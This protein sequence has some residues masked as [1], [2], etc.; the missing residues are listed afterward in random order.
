MAATFKLHGGATEPK[1][2]KR[3]MTNYSFQSPLWLRFTSSPSELSGFRLNP[4]SMRPVN[5]GNQAFSVLTTF[6]TWR[7]ITIR[8]FSHVGR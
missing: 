4:R 3:H 7:K 5:R 2:V 6:E 8:L 1:Q